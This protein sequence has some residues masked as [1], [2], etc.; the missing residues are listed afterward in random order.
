MICV[1]NRVF[2]CARKVEQSDAANRRILIDGKR[3]VAML[4]K[5][6]CVDTFW[7]DL[8]MFA[9][10]IAE[11]CSVQGCAGAENAPTCVRNHLVRKICK[12]V[13]RIGDDQ[14]KRTGFCED[15]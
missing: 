1:L 9:K 6:I 15:N 14:H 13:D 3:G 8:E 12:D 11:S 7:V 10:M 2:C 5:Y 4:S